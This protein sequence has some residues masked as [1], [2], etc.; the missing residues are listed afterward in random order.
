MIKMKMLFMSC[1]AIVAT[2]QKLESC[3]KPLTSPSRQTMSL[4]PS[5]PA[6]QLR[7]ETLREEKAAAQVAFLAAV[8][9]AKVDWEAELLLALEEYR[10]G[11][12]FD[13]IQARILDELNRIRNM[14][15]NEDKQSLT[16]QSKPTPVAQLWT[17]LPDKLD[18]KTMLLY[19]IEELSHDCN[20]PSIKASNEYVITPMNIERAI[21][22]H[23][24][25]SS[26]RK[27]IYTAVTAEQDAQDERDRTLLDQRQK[28]QLEEMEARQRLMG[29]RF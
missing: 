13:E 4:I 27:E 29:R 14:M 10:D 25:L 15:R 24:I 21:L 19:A 8:E 22:R 2:C 20:V 12:G 26:I 1:F 18:I 6:V 28:A 5:S 17:F 11:G 9:V 16:R 23:R 3:N 7:L